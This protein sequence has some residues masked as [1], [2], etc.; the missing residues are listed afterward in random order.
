MKTYN[1]EAIEKMYQKYSSTTVS[2][3]GIFE[4]FVPGEGWKTSEDMQEGFTHITP[5]NWGIFSCFMDGA[6][7]IAF[8]IFDKEG[9]RVGS[10]SFRMEEI[11]ENF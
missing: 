7:A 5:D 9:F 3:K 4:W 8:E 10:P 2:I 11:A 6:T 1:R